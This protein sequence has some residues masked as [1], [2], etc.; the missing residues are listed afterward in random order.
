MISKQTVLW[1]LIV[2]LTIIFNII[3]SDQSMTE[4]TVQNQQVI[5][6]VIYSGN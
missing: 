1:S 4:L 6:Q 5:I 3:T 2:L